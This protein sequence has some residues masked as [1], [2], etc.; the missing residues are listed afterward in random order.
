MI[1]HG[2]SGSGFLSQ[3]CYF[4]DQKLTIVTLQ[5]TYRAISEADLAHGIADKIL[6]T[7]NKGTRLATWERETGV[8]RMI[9]AHLE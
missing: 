6:A 1:G 2:G 4:P 8:L 3:T 7:K 9:S 5:N